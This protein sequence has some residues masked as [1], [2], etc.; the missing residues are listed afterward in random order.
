MSPHW[1][2]QVQR[3]DSGNPCA[4]KERKKRFFFF[5]ETEKNKISYPPG[6][7]VSDSST[8]TKQKNKKTACK[9]SE[10]K[11]AKGKTQ[12]NRKPTKTPSRQSQQ[13]VCGTS[14]IDRFYLL[15]IIGPVP[16]YRL[17]PAFVDRDFPT[18]VPPPPVSRF[19]GRPPLEG[20]VALP[21]PLRLVFETNTKDTGQ[22]KG[23]TNKHNFKTNKRTEL[24]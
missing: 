5:K 20:Y 22:R 21:T 7:N 12:T 24:I 17:F 2:G 9:Q 8:K 16:R 10:T 4:L 13:L 6:G 15:L 1:I 18:A 19:L 23:R 11:R 3:T 14:S